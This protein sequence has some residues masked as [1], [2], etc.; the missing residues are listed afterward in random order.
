MLYGTVHGMC[1]SISFSRLFVVCVILRLFSPTNPV[2]DICN[3]R[4][5]GSYSPSVVHFAHS[6]SH[7]SHSLDLLFSLDSQSHSCIHMQYGLWEYVWITLSP[8]FSIT[9][10]HV[11]KRV[12]VSVCVFACNTL[13]PTSIL[14]DVNRIIV[15]TSHSFFYTCTEQAIQIA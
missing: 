5:T 13:L 1:K 2:E 6:F 15:Y 11:C 3:F 9:T 14:K 10:V 7:T 4:L 12:S 8:A